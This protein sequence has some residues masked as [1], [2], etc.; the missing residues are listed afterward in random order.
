[1]EI[2]K[3]SKRNIKFQ[4]Y[5]FLILFLTITILLAWVSKKYSVEYDWT[6]S[7]R[8][9]LS[10]ATVELVKKINEPLAISAF[11]VTADKDN[12]EQIQQLIGKYQK[13]NDK[14]TLEFINPDTNPNLTREMGIRSSGEIVISLHS[15]V[16]HIEALSESNITNALHR[17]SRAATRKFAYITGHGERELQGAGNFDFKLFADYLKEKGIVL[18]AVNLQGVKDIPADYAAVILANPRKNFIQHE[19][20]LLTEYIDKGGNFFWLHDPKEMH[21]LEPLAAA[22]EIEFQP[23]VIID[24]LVQYFGQHPSFITIDEK[25]YKPHPI[26][27]DF[28]FATSYSFATGI[29][30]KVIDKSKFQMQ[31]ILASDPRMYLETS[32]KAQQGPDDI[33]GPI[34]FGMAMERN[35]D[36]TTD[37]D[38]KSSN[39]DK[40]KQQR[41]FVVGDSDFLSNLL[42]NM[43]GNK[44]LGFRILNWLAFDDSFIN[45]PSRTSPGKDIKLNI[46]IWYGL[47]ALFLFV[48]PIGFAVAGIVIWM[49]RRK[50]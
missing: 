11:V 14:I 49:K 25:H 42:V 33:K 12:K 17:L 10:E 46:N 24:E 19:V 4:N 20:H 39:P 40:K 29:K 41:I 13:V 34:D 5:T 37:K 32:S 28:P 47:S 9:K 22:L 35:L 6:S 16:E 36:S 8:N 21:G 7:K 48:M 44:D 2:N 23:G 1:M 38:A 3:Q 50:R 43:V 26:T 45:I 27:R 15:K 18:E 30:R 31:P